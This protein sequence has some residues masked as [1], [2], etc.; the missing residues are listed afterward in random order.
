MTEPTTSPIAIIMGVAGSGKTAVGGRLAERLGVPYVDGD[1]LH[2]QANIDKMSAGHPLDDDDRRPWLITIGEWLHD[3]RE[4]GAVA[5]CSALRRSYRDLLRRSCPGVPFIHL[6]GSRDLIVERVSG[7]EGHFMP[8]SLVDSQFDT[9]E[10]L[11]PDEPGIT[12]E[13]TATVDEIVDRTVAWL[14]GHGDTTTLN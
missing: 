4:T 7:R 3:H 13:V 10:P 5:T 14:A 8:A 2:P 1:D 12:V 6:A 9:L 11:E